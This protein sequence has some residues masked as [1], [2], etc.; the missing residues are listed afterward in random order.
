[1]AAIK[2]IEYWVASYL[3]APLHPSVEQDSQKLK[4]VS[5]QNSTACSGL[6]AHDRVT[7]TT[8]DVNWLVGFVT[9][10]FLMIEKGDKKER[11]KIYITKM[12]G[13]KRAEIGI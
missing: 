8:L 6:F 4:P 3:A 5:L 13:K 11:E 2:T 12:V 9:L 10:F 1:M 7:D